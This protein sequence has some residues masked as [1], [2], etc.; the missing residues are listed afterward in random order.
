MNGEVTDEECR[1]NYMPSIVSMQGHSA[2]LGIVFY[3]FTE[4]RP[5]ECGDILPFPESYDGYAFI[6]FHGS[7]NRAVP[8]GY[9]VVYIPFDGSG[10]AIG[11]PVDFLAHEPPNAQWEDG[12]RPVDVDFDSCGRL[13]VT[14]DGTFSEGSKVVT[15]QYNL[16]NETQT[17]PAPSSLDGSSSPTDESIT[18]AP[19][20]TP[21]V[22]CPC[23]L[24]RESGAPDTN[25]DSSSTNHA[26]PGLIVGMIVALGML[27]GST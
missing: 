14:S 23:P 22:T 4:D 21:S 16:Y 13:I 19:T 2:P 1:S 6:A 3:K 24:P 15:V 7:W 17:S 26:R 25:L 27:Y 10:N 20:L 8:T 5:E 11:P 18:I 9:K 12:F